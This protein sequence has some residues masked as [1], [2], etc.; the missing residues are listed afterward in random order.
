[1]SML[2]DAQISFSECDN[3]LVALTKYMANLMPFGTYLFISNPFELLI[4]VWPLYIRGKITALLTCWCSLFQK[5]EYEVI[6]QKAGE[7]G[8]V[9]NRLFTILITFYRSYALQIKK[10]SE[11]FKLLDFPVHLSCTSWW[12][13]WIFPAAVLSKHNKFH[14]LDNVPG[15]T[16]RDT[17]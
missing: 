1:M 14:P 5:E 4:S 7:Y 12:G 9:N 8:T 13:V 2:R 10:M 6:K 16:C 3:F 17:D 15:K 11:K